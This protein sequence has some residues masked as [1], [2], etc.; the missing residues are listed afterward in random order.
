MR[1]RPGFASRGASLALILTGVL[2]AGCRLSMLCGDAADGSVAGIE[3]LGLEP[4]VPTFGPRDAPVFIEE[5]DDFQ[6][7]Y[8]RRV[9]STLKALAQKYEGSVRFAFRHNPL[10][11]H[12]E[13]FGAAKAAVAAMRQGQFWPYHE[14][15]FANAHAL[16]EPDLERYAED[17]GLDLRQFRA[18]FAD[19][20]TAELVRR[21]KERA[22]RYGCR[23]TPNFLIN[24]RLMRGAQPVEAFSAV[25]EE[26][27][28][29]ARE[30][31]SDGVPAHQLA[32]VLFTRNRAAG[33]DGA[34]AALPSATPPQPA[35]D[36]DK[37]YAIPDDGQAAVRGAPWA[38]VTLV[39]FGDLQCPF[40]ARAFE[41]LL[42]VQENAAAGVRLVFR[43]FPLDFHPEAEL[44]A[45]A[46]LA[47]GRQ[48]RFWPFVERVF[49]GQAGLSREALLTVARQLELTPDRYT[50]D[51]DDPRLSAQVRADL[52]LGR[53]LGVTGTPTVFINGR[54]LAGLRDEDTYRQAV[55]AALAAAPPAPPTPPARTDDDSAAQAPGLPEAGP[56]TTTA[57][58]TPPQVGP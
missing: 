55:Q 33:G 25:I 40:T 44:A 19:P 54:P 24:G 36:P 29:K 3:S 42:A 28:A 8:C 53:S 46:A 21:D 10:P 56:P 16:S 35:L 45:R 49:A 14:Q 27:L 52:A 2:F 7:P 11:Y 57:P 47:A 30:L 17:L 32:A 51:L 41:R 1:R 9:Q 39:L 20:R 5:F 38:P 50:A 43:H 58:P 18:D 48:E 12:A 23:G 22:E 13:A 4:D 15:L 37:T 31:V 6:C 26:E 34:A